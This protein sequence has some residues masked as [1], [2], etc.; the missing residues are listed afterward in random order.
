LTAYGSLRDYFCS[1]PNFNGRKEIHRGDDL[2]IE[3]MDLG[4]SPLA[5][6]S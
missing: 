1:H 6:G 5:K 3:W 2:H 4:K